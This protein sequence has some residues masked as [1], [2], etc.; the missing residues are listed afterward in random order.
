MLCL[1]LS[2]IAIISVKGVDYR[3]FIHDISKSNAIHLLKNSALF[4]R[5]CI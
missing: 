5:G 4:D 3:C 1:N 2:N